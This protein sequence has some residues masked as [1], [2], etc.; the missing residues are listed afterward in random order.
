MRRIDQIIVHCTATPAGRETSV[1]EIRRWHLERG[2]SDIGYHFVIGL[3]GCIE[4]GRPL[5]KIGAHCKGK[6]RH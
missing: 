1:D 2:F 5:V 3:D 4:D 6:N